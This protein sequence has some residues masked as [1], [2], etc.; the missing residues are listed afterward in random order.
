[1]KKKKPFVVFKI[2]SEKGYEQAQIYTEDLR[3]VLNEAK[4]SKT[5]TDVA[6]QLEY[7]GKSTRI[8]MK[9][10]DIRKVIKQ[11]ELFVSLV[12]NRLS[13]YLVDVTKQ[14]SD[15]PKLPIMGRENEIEKI[16][17]YLSQTTRNNVFLVGP[18]EVGKTTLA[19]EIA[20]QMSTNECPKEFYDK[21]L[22]MFRPELF[23][24]IKHD[25]IYEMMVKDIMRFLA[26]NKEK[27]V[28][29]IDKS[30]YMKTDELLIYMLYA[31]L[32]KY[33]IPLITTSDEENFDNYFLADPT[34]SKYVNE[35]YIEEPELE[36]IGPMMKY[37]ISRLQKKYEIKISDAMINFG[38]FT[39]GLADSVS[40][41]P[42]NV[43]NIFEKAFIEAKRKDKEEVDKQCILSCYNSYLK[44]YN[45]ITEEEKKK[46]AYHETG[47]YVVAMMCP[48]V[49]D[50]KIAFVSILPMMDFL[51]VNWNYKILGKTLDYTKDYFLDKIAIYLAGRIAER[52]I[53]SKDNSGASS[54]LSIASSIAE[55]ML[56]IYGLSE[57]EGNKNRSYVN[58][59]W[60]IKSYLISESRKEEFD[61]EIQQLIDEGYQIAEKIINENTEL[62][63]IIANKL[64]EEEILTGEQ[65]T[66]ICEEYNKNK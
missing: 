63:K 12:P 8:T 52:L 41:N 60:N 6:L 29:Y 10:S 11:S 31:C 16:W 48:H 24:K 43:V 28:L 23:D 9:V 20:R 25:S 50:E 59:N 40:S 57:S 47:H 54:D 65:L 30:L 15:H 42:G 62:I 18:K 66:Q 22:I 4:L 33:H 61:K 2:K 7:D 56:T 44:L 19:Y 53:T 3:K 35:V 1:M 34:I 14:L 46:M 55:Q 64:V 39:S 45:S 21:R 32:M 38:I 49:Q 37:H 58:Y 5:T 13:T 26:K 27:V 36:E 17:F 51:G